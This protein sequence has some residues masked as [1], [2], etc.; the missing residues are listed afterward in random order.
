MSARNLIV[1]TPSVK[2][3]PTRCQDIYDAAG[4]VI[5]THEQVG[6]FEERSCLFLRGA[7]RRFEF[8]K[9]GQLLIGTRNEM[10]SAAA[11]S[12]CDEGCSSARMP[13]CGASP[14]PIDFAQIVSEQPTE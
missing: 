4:N 3:R 10:L 6:A 14:T 13:A 8:H 2:K 7:K 12:V 11:M 1:I 9:R 5:E